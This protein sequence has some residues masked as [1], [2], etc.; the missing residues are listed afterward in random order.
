MSLTYS[1]EQPAAGVSDCTGLAF[2]PLLAARLTNGDVPPLGETSRAC[3]STQ[4]CENLPQLELWLTSDTS[5]SAS[6][7]PLPARTPALP[8]PRAQASTGRKQA[9]S[10]KP[11]A[12]S[13]KA[14]QLGLALRTVLGCELEALTGRSLSWRHSTTPAGRSWWVLTT[15]ARPT[16]ES[17]CGSLLP[18][19][20]AQEYGS[21]QGGA[22]G[23]TGPVRPSLRTILLPTATGNL[24]S[25]SMAKWK[26]HWGF[27]ATPMGTDGRED[28][29]MNPQCPF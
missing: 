2:A 19:P 29:A 13:E 20:S 14:D 26:G 3:A 25:P 18:T 23:R 16:S 1:V 12:S 7:A 6:S 10:W 9:F 21:N 4:T 22:M 28:G 11:S 27:I 5:Q 8:T 17:V 24:A 15:L